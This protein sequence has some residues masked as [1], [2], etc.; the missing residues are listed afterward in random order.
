MAV[1][2]AGHPLPQQ[3]RVPGSHPAFGISKH[4]KQA[5][6]SL[7]VQS[8]STHV[9]PWF[10]QQCGEEDAGPGAPNHT[11]TAPHVPG[12]AWRLLLAKGWP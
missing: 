1:L 2:G 10:Q 11:W 5:V 9:L 4:E 8:T 3:L 6:T 7:L 12:G